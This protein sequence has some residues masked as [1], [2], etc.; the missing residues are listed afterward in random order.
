MFVGFAFIGVIALAGFSAVIALAIWQSKRR[1]EFLNA[2]GQAAA[3]LGWYPAPPNPWLSGVAADIFQRGK[4]G[5]MFAGDFRGRGM[6]ALDYTYTT[7]STD[8]NGSTTTTTHRVFVVALN[9]PVALPPLKLT[10]DSKVRR[11]FGGRD[12][13]LESKAFND[14]FRVSCA[15]ERY[16]SAVLHPRL[17]EW[18]LHNPG[19]EWQV[20]GNALVTWGTGSFTIPDTLARLEVMSR[21]IDLLPPFVLRDYG[22]PVY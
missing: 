6:C 19:L 4:P 13:E 9:L 18:M 5:E 12:I 3:Q 16:A 15:D 10:M 1:R 20:A 14:A 7:T 11:F 22:Q 17:M 2:R 8:S 21:V